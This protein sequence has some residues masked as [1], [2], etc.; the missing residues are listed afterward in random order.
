M[1]TFLRRRFQPLLWLTL[2]G[3]LCGWLYHLFFFAEDKTA[4]LPGETSH[5]HYQI[6]LKCSACHDTTPDGLLVSAV[7]NQA[8]LNCHEQDLEEASDSHPLVK[9]RKPEN[10]PFLA[11]IDASRCVTCHTEHKPEHTAPAGLTVPA[12]YCLHCHQATI[13]ERETHRDLPFQTC[14][15]SGCHNYH[16]NR[17]LY[18]RHLMRHSLEPPVLAVPRVA[19]VEELSAY[20]A[21]NAGVS[22][23]AVTDADYPPAVSGAA[24]HASAWSEDKHAAA[25][26]NCSAC[27]DPRGDGWSDKVPL[28]TCATCH[29]DAHDGFLR[30][31][32]GMRLAAGLSPM[33][34][35]QARQPMKPAAAHRPL[36]CTAC[37][38]T[39]GS[40]DFG[41]AHASMAACVQCHDDDHTRAYA[42]SPH[43]RLWER[44]LAG[45][46]SP[47]SGVSCATC[48][49]P[50]VEDGHGGLRVEHNQSANLR[51]S[52]KMLRN[53][54]QSCHGLPFA[55]DSLAD[56]ALVRRNFTGRPAVHVESCDWARERATQRN[57]PLMMELLR[58]ESAAPESPGT[59]EKKTSQQPRTK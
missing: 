59:E 50:R 51:P 56:D 40:H 21:E 6:E 38:G 29:S 41:R 24:L 28:S 23:L 54:C 12:D 16:D 9:F 13:E 34:P 7:S 3:G 27:H 5:G 37:H 14:A 4:I 45:A 44:E 57:D 8:C 17:S 35:G 2:S 20:L 32:H 42:D 1:P 53:V 36:D 15:T 33:T 39:G 30:G 48:H 22:R 52:E 11:K 10:Q 55:I 31:K 46:L 18:E 19:G 47:G 43:A 25:G 26:V 49:M 58:N